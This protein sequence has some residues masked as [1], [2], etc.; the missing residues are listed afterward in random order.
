[1]ACKLARVLMFP[2]RSFSKQRAAIEREYGQVSALGYS[3]PLLAVL[4]EPFFF[5]F[6]GNA[7]HV[8]ICAAC[9]CHDALPQCQ[10]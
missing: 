8:L 2:Q 9:L 10:Q 3:C 1:M 4:L 6:T 5:F 7:S